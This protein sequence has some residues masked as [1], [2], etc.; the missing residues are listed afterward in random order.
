[1]SA[2]GNGQRNL[3]NTRQM[4]SDREMRRFKRAKEIQGL[5]LKHKLAEPKP[6]PDYVPVEFGLR[7]ESRKWTVLLKSCPMCNW[8]G[9]HELCVMKKPFEKDAFWVKCRNPKCSHRTPPMDSSQLAI[10]HWQLVAA[11]SK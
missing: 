6:R 4:T 10:R 3:L 1:M 7:D 9:G 8:Q 11:L 2:N 5:H